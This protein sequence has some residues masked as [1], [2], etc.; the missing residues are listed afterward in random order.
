MT[1]VLAD[2]R[3]VRVVVEHAIGS[4]QRPM[5]TAQLEAKFSGMADAVLGAAR[6]RELMAACWQVG[7][8][9]DLRGLVSLARP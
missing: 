3:R 7:Q 9:A 1:A 4:L 6:C 5:S 8:V 2:G